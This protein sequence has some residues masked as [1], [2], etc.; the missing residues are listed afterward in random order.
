MYLFEPPQND[1]NGKRN[2]DVEKDKKTER[3][4]E[5]WIKKMGSKGA[6][7]GGGGGLTTRRMERKDDHS[8]TMHKIFL[9]VYKYR[10]FCLT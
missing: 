5:G 4:R 7:V 1:K 10:A 3:E 6:R 8:S 9:S 2:G